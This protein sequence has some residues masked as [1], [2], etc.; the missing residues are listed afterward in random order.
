MPGIEHIQGFEPRTDQLSKR[1]QDL[2]LVQPK[3]LKTP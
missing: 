3:D 1:I 2:K